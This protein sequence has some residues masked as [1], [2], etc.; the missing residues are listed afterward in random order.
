VIPSQRSHL[1]VAATTH[2]GMSGKNNEDNYAVSAH[3]LSSSDST[4]S[5]LA[6]LADGVGGHL[7]GEVASEIATESISKFILDSDATNPT[8]ILEDAFIQANLRVASQSDN[9][10]QRLGMGSTCACIW[11][12]GDCIYT[13]SVGDSR[14]YLIRADEIKQITTDHTWV[15]EAID[16][17]I[18]KPE[19][20]RNHPRAHVIRRYL[21]SKKPVV[22]D[23]R[24]RLSPEE[25][26]EQ[27]V[28]NQG[29]KLVP[30]DQFLL[31]SD[32]LTDLVDDQEILDAIQQQKQEQAIH[33][34]VDLANARGGHD[35]ITIITLKVPL[36]KEEVKLNVKPVKSSRFKI[37]WQVYL[38]ISIFIL[39]TTALAIILYLYASRTPPITTPTV[40]YMN[41]ILTP[42][43]Q[44]TTETPQ[45]SPTTSPTPTTTAT[46]IL[47]TYTPWP[48]NTQTPEP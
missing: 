1:H 8:E 24:L 32:G 12:I 38:A 14:I 45:P 15:Q 3:R 44:L 42:E 43:E 48:T 23:F 33:S 41:E 7:A 17:G 39:I 11:V 28:A 13:A 22:P 46:S 5:V 6:V 26:D 31:C 27:A 18:I 47:E 25:T 35:N 2:P 40:R 30:G 20:A 29:M 16:H 10:D 21:G 19:Q 4:P 37:S 34:L 9:D 36:T